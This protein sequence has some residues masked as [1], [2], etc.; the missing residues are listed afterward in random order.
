MGSIVFFKVKSLSIIV[1]K[2]FVYGLMGLN[3]FEALISGSVFVEKVHFGHSYDSSEYSTCKR[4]VTQGNLFSNNSELKIFWL[5][6]CQ[7]RLFKL[8]G[9]CHCSEVEKAEYQK[10]VWSLFQL[11]C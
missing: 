7:F 10:Q 6:F 3:V 9:E 11:C 2:S 8:I 5:I 4:A 1:E